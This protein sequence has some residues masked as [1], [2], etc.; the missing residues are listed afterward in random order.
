MA[1]RLGLVIGL[2][3]TCLAWWGCKGDFNSTTIPP[4][5]GGR[6]IKE[7]GGPTDG[8]GGTCPTTAPIDLTTFPWKPPSLPQD[9]KCQADD[10]LAMRGYLTAN[11][12]A[13]NEDFENFVK[14]RDTVCHDC[15]FADAKGATWP[16]APVE[17]GKVLTFNVGACFE[18]ISGSQACGKAVQ[19]A[20]DC[21]FDACIQCPSAG[22]LES[23]RVKSRSGVCKPAYDT[24]RTACVD[25]KGADELCGS[26]FDSIRIQCVSAATDAG[27]L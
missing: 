16:P 25:S 12:K 6:T 24:S 14:N 9:G 10:V 8:G 20:W 5:D 3:V 22:D 1:K 19:N 15:I 23:C 2:A 21:E 27:K 11:P 17:D 18:I 26:P 7:A 13:T 4:E